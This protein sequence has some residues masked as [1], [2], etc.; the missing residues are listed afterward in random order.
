MDIADGARCL[1]ISITINYNTWSRV[2]VDDV[3]QYGGALQEEIELAFPNSSVIITFSEDLLPEDGQAASCSVYVKGDDVE[4][5]TAR[6]LTISE[7]VWNA[8]ERAR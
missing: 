5:V 6:I 8:E 7:Q 1:D 3:E 4:S 2:T